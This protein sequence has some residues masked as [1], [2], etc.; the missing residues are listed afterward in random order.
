MGLLDEQMALID[1]A[2]T[3][4]VRG[5][6][7]E[8]RGMALAVVDLPVPVGSMVHV[9]VDHGSGTKLDGTVIG[10]DQSQTIVM[11]LGGL[12]GVRRGDLVIA[13]QFSQF[14]KVGRSLLGRV[15]DG[16]GRPI[17]GKGPLE[18]TV[19]RPLE[20]EPV[21]PMDR[22][23]I[24]T[25]LMTGVRAIDALVSVGLGQRVGVFAAP[26]LG[27]STLLATMSRH[28]SAAVSVIAL[29]GE[30][31]R[32]VRSFIDH[33]LGPEGMARSVVVAATSNESP[34][35]RLRAA[36][37]A[38]TIA[39]FFRDK[40]LDCLLIMDSVTRLCHAQRQIGLAAGEPPATKG[41]PPSVFA[42]LASLL[43]RS[44]RT[45]QGS[46]TGFYA[47]LMEG[48]D[49]TDP[50]PDAVRGILDGHIQLSPS[51]A[52]R[53]HWPAIDVLDSISR[54]SDDVTSS[55]HQQARAQ[56]LRSI[57]A[58]N[59]VE[60]LLNV[61]AYAAGSNVDYD[62]AI[63]VK[64]AIDKLLRQG[65]GE[66][67]A[68]GESNKTRQQLLALAEQIQRVAGQLAKGS[69]RQAHVAAR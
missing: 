58:Y 43:E 26:G 67:A 41:Y 13:H 29:V 48:D 61:G 31:G 28:T 15:I 40:G 33:Q 17:D 7:S 32:E 57:H 20:P 60:E 63:A 36:M 59:Q 35:M 12:E 64:P 50:I 52:Q 65:P 3:L 54:V 34:V 38:N 11:P 66:V 10:F 44:G 49:L 39:E 21:D 2:A 22:P 68:A 45:S 24:D 62:L 46:I 4:E 47:V 9:C 53:G 6:V 5:R 56:V 23:V 30:R 51:L 14:V 18:D 1:R 25:P 8:V 69:S 27:K 19:V 16:L 37:V 42:M 55:E